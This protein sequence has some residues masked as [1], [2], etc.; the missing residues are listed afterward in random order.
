VQLRSLD[1]SQVAFLPVDPTA[2]WSDTA[3]TSKPVTGFPFGPALVTVFTNGIPSAAKYLVFVP[4]LV[5]NSATSLATHGLP[6]HPQR[7]SINLPLSGNPG[8]E[9]RSS[10][11]IG[12]NGSHIIEFTFNNAISSVDSA[13]TTCGSITST[14]LDGSN[15]YAVRFAG[16]AC[17]QQYVT[18]TLSGV[19]DTY[20]QTL[21]S[22]SVTVGLLLGDTTAN[23]FVNSSD[24]AQTQSQSG[25]PLSAS[26]FRE[27]VTVNG[28][29]NSTDISVVQ[30]KSGTA[31]G[32]PPALIGPQRAPIRSQ[33]TKPTKRSDR[34]NQ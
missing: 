8:I 12:G 18:V 31:L 21:A 25:Q 30:S 15:T 32:S 7:F 23:R 20:G 1:N 3:F 14:G 13:V 2:G 19:H 4:P 11:G 34:S 16:G 29:I 9:C 5:L 17:N 22:A 27:D 33:R 10:D 24:I 28:L 6:N 26:N